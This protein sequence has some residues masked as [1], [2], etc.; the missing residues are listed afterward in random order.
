MHVAYHAVDV[1]AQGLRPLFAD[2]LHRSAA[3]DRMHL[4]AR[5]PSQQADADGIGAGANVQG[6]LARMNLDGRHEAAQELVPQAE[7]GEEIRTIIIRS[8]IGKH[9]I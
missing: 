3:V 8:N 2:L 1:K 5:F 6:S 4:E 9:L 7:A